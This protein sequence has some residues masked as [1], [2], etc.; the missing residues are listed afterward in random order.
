M[1]VLGM[2]RL[3]CQSNEN[4]LSQAMSK[5]HPLSGKNARLVSSKHQPIDERLLHSRLRVLARSF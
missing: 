3:F 2:T 1:L 4:D 5:D